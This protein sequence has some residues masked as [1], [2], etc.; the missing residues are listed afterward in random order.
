MGTEG[1]AS[2][3]RLVWTVATKDAWINTNFKMPNVFWSNGI[4][5]GYRSVLIRLPQDYYVVLFTNSPEMNV[6]QLYNAGVAAFKA[7]MQHNF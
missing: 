1:M 2:N 3:D 7:G 4:T 5:G 6:T